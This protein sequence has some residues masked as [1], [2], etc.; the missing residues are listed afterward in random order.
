[1]AVVKKYSAQ[2]TPALRPGTSA[3]IDKCAEDRRIT[4]SECAREAI[5]K[6]YPGTAALPAVLDIHQRAVHRGL[7]QRV[8]SL[9]PETLEQI[10][11]ARER[12]GV[13]YV[14]DVIRDALEREFGT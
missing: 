7:M 4:F 8:I 12:T 9:Q 1:M 13:K 2:V 11:E 6:Y 3:A 5:E 10:E 14:A